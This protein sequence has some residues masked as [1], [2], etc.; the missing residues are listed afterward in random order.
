M[1]RQVEE[2]TKDQDQAL[3][4]LA[5]AHAA[6]PQECGDLVATE[7]SAGDIRVEVASDAVIYSR[8]AFAERKGSADC[9]SPRKEGLKSSALEL[10]SL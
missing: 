1:K 5:K 8:T 10:I 6:L 2:A 7:A 9:S 4:R 3:T